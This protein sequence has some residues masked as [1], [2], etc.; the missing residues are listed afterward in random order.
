MMHKLL[1]SLGASAFALLLALP[2]HAQYASTPPVQDGVPNASEYNNNSF[3]TFN[4][5]TWYMT[6]DANKLYIGKTGGTT[7]EP[8]IVYLD[9]NP[10]L[11]VNGGSDQQGSKLGVNEVLRRA[12]DPNTQSGVVPRLPFRADVRVYCGTNGQISVSRAN[13]TG[14]WGPESQANVTVTS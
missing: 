11:P 2:G 1:Y 4:G 5:G 12:T 6:W 14:G 9:I 13:G 3:Q 7:E 10:T 8:A